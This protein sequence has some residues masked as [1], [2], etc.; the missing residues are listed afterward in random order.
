[1]RIIKIDRDD[2]DANYNLGRLYLKFVK[3]FN[4]SIKHFQRCTKKD[5]DEAIEMSKVIK[6]AKSFYNI[7]LI[8]DKIGKV[9]EAADYYN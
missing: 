1:M 4:L 3:D 5:Q 7:G 2:V 9:Q 6:I 8:F